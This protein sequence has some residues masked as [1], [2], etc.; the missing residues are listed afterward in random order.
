MIMP[1]YASEKPKRKQIRLTKHNYNRNGLY[2]I[3]IVTQDRL[4]VLGKIESGTMM[5]S[6][7]GELAASCVDKIGTVYPSVA[8]EAYAVIP[9]HV[10]ILLA[11][12]DEVH[13][14]SISRVV[15]QWKGVVSKGAEYSCWQTNYHENLLHTGERLRTVRRY[16][17]N[18]PVDWEKDRYNPLNAKSDLI[19]GRSMIVPA[20]VPPMA[21][22]NEEPP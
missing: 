21:V 14:P 2:L 16:I 15:Q 4:E 3:T 22:I 11:L 12:L 5:L 19:P 13:N 7:L 8:V 17:Q 1:I 20:K 9:N 6:S 10:H 18:N